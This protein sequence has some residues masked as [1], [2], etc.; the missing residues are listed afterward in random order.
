M[1][2]TINYPPQRTHDCN[3][4]DV[5][6]TDCL[7]TLQILTKKPCP[8]D[9][10]NTEKVFNS[11][12]HNGFPVYDAFTDRVAA[13]KY[14]YVKNT[15]IQKKTHSVQHLANYQ[16]QVFHG[17]STAEVTN[18]KSRRY[19]HQ[20]FVQSKTQT[21]CVCESLNSVNL[22]RSQSESSQPANQIIFFQ[23]LS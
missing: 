12:R 6:G 1:T 14:Q 17:K 9:L 19:K 18:Q 3:Q 8:V 22:S 21:V 4:T 5:R 10:K 7:H 23:Q 13:L 16:M 20:A 15:M 11:S 2:K